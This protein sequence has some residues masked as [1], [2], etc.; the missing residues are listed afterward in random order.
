MTFSGHRLY[1]KSKENL[2]YTQGVRKQEKVPFDM[3]LK[4]KSKEIVF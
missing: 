2:I 4:H 1:L 3:T